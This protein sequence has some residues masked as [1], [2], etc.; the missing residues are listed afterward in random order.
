MSKHTFE[1]SLEGSALGVFLQTWAAV[2]WILS[3]T[4]WV[5][6][7]RPLVKLAP[8]LAL[9][10]FVGLA[11]CSAVA[12]SV[13]R[14]PLRRLGAF[15]A[16]A[17]MVAPI[18]QLLV[19]NTDAYWLV[20]AFAG[21]IIPLLPLADSKT[22]RWH[23]LG[24]G[25]VLFSVPT[26]AGKLALWGA[27][28]LPPQETRNILLQAVFWVATM[29]FAQKSIQGIASPKGKLEG[30]PGG[31]GGLSLDT[32]NTATNLSGVRSVE[33]QAGASSSS[34]NLTKVN[35]SGAPASPAPPMDG[36]SSGAIPRKAWEEQSTFSDEP[37]DA[38]SSQVLSRS[39]L[40]EQDEQ[41]RNQ[42]TRLLGPVVHLM[43]KVFR[44]YSALGFLA[45]GPSGQLLLNAKFGKGNVL[46]DAHIAPGARLLG[47][48]LRSGLLTG[49]VANYGESP[50]YY[51]DGERVLSL[52]ALPVRNEETG[53]LQALLVVDHKSPRAFSDEHY[54]YFKRFAGIASALVT[55][56]SARNAIQRQATITNTFYDIQSRLTRHLKTEDLLQVLDSALKTLFPLERLAISM[57]N[58]Q[59]QMAQIQSISGSVPGPAVGTYYDLADQ[60]SLVGAVFRTGREL[61][62]K[63]YAASS[64]S[65]FESR[66]DAEFD[67]KPQEAIAA[68][69]LNDE[70]Q[71]FGVLS[72]ETS[73]NGS[74]SELDAKLLS[75]IAAIAAGA[76]TRARMYQ[77][78]ERLATIDG[79]TQVPNHRHFQTLLNQHIDIATRYG[80]NIGLLLFDIDHFKQFNDTYGHAI[81]DLVLKEVARTVSGAIRSTDV[82]ARYGGEEFVVLIPQSDATGAMQSAERVR[83]AVEGM[84]VTHEG[85]SL[86]VTISIGVCL[87]PEMATV[88]QDFIDG[89]DKAMYYSKKTGRN[90]VTM[91]GPES[92]AL[93][94]EKEA[95]G[96]AH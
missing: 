76:L 63:N 64:R 10:I 29:L 26:L 20:L 42:M 8:G 96:G 52:M 53:D 37:Q 6:T 43:H 89:S 69:F 77:E 11:V 87:F 45:D 72:L 73:T 25:L 12:V 88:K 61:L 31:H 58:P 74:Y 54:Q 56:Q 80:H 5:L 33:S 13:W 92:E 55:V 40:S 95:V 70:R 57:W 9:G 17:S 84:N 24:A 79:L 47:N 23:I 34:L 16:M 67:W 38:T 75:A 78:M 36:R 81:G 51:P 93:A 91:Y 2:V 1:P 50:E 21:W 46:A 44:S 19:P 30:R 22:D 86:H 4:G 71:C 59:R 27:I 49:D 65:M 85:K 83:A 41:A 62:V 48:A 60:R 14:A 3:S 7:L 35:L 28:S 39:I 94:K 18:A 32:S 66:L 15:G 90:R 68:P 82:L